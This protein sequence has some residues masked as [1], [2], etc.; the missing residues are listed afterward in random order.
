MSQ[1]ES[2]WVFSPLRMRGEKNYLFT[3]VLRIAATAMLFFPTSTTK[4]M[5]MSV[6]LKYYD[7]ATLQKKNQ[8]VYKPHII[9]SCG[10]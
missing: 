5:F 6:Y 3:F 4:T 2:G 9:L 1:N 7:K 10:K 8:V